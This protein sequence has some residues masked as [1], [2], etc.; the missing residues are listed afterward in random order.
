MAA[1][2]RITND[3]MVQCKNGTHGPLIYVSSRNAG[4]IVEWQE[5]GEIQD[6]DYGEL[7]AMRGSQPRFFRDNWILIEDAE[8]LRKLGMDRYYKNALTTENFDEVFHWTASDIRE[9]VPKMSDGMKD[10]IRV[11][12]KE[13]VKSGELDSR[14][15]I[16]ALNEVLSCNL[17]ED[18]E[19]ETKKSSR[20]KTVEVFNVE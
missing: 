7:L 12:A 11:R 4:Y 17:E 20:K 9:K 1:A 16:K 5:F 19:F 15:V 3:T 10:S 6:I 14:S 2:K 18:I 8:V 13:L